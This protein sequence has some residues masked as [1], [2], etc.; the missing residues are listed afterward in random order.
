DVVVELLRK[1]LIQLDALI[2][3]GNAVAGSVVRANDRGVAPAAAATEI[4]PLEH[5]DVG[6][7]VVLCQIVGGGQTVNAAADNDDI[8]AI[9]HRALG[10][11]RLLAKNLHPQASTASVCPA[12]RPIGAMP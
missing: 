10:P 12:V 3:K 5:G 7:A 1:A 8:V 6:H 11:H 2:V 4:V 9:P